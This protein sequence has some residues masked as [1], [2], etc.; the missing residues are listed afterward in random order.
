MEKGLE[1]PL[2][3]YR[4]IALL[5]QGGMAD[6]YLA[7]TQ[8]P[9]GF[10]K[11]LVV[12]LARFTGDAMHSTMFL[13][14]ARLAAQLSHPNVVQTYEIG[15]EGSRHY[16]VMEYLD[17]VNLSRLRQRSTRVGGI[18]LRLSVHIL[19]QVLEGLEYA[20]Q[21][22]G[23]DGKLLKVVHRDLTP[24]NIMVTAQGVVKILDFGIAKGVDT[25]SFTQA[26]R[27]SGKLNYMPPEQM[28]GESVDGR[29]D[30]FSVGVILAEAVLGHKFWG[31]QSGAMVAQQ[32]GQGQI[33][34][35]DIEGIDP[36]LRRICERALSA[37]RE[38]RYPNAAVFKA[39]LTRYLQSLGGPVDR[40]E[41]GQ[42]VSETVAEDRAKLQAVI[43]GQMQRISQ[44]TIAQKPPPPDLPHIEHTP[45]SRRSVHTETTVKQDD[46]KTNRLVGDDD[47][48]IEVDKPRHATPLPVAPAKSRMGLIAL[49][50]GA[51]L[52]GV[53]I[54]VVLLRP[55]GNQQVAS[56]AKTPPPAPVAA[57]TPPPPAPPPAPTT[58][59]LEVIVSPPDATLT[60]DGQSLGTNPYVGNQPR[61]T[62]VHELVVAA[63][64]FSPVT[65][66]FTL[67]RD[68][69]LQLHLD[70]VAPPV[71]K[72]EPPPPPPPQKVAAHPAPVKVKAAPHATPKTVAPPPDPT[73]PPPAVV[74]APP[75]APPADTKRSIDNDVFDK[76]PSKRALDS[77]VFDDGGK[78][79]TIDRDNPWKK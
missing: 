4:L 10:Q 6:V 62:Q 47:V 3:R 21:S 55:P 56:E 68:L 5:G 75:P 48:V 26:G 74:T 49:V 16:I 23:L 31:N 59:R 76:K 28:R 77:N 70:P 37:D 72:A 22:R 53:L 64:G 42:F 29:A 18:P 46:V 52:V 32:L 51:V 78:K 67:E 41:L 58:S 19:Q 39:D 45:S 54:T 2:G 13:D 17:G 1:T 69:M 34:S 25:H 24:S 14:E 38:T 44:L 7:C 79:A 63:K 73:P 40:E 27:Y 43:D 33:P 11:L 61:D 36:E 65:R 15:E 50:V 66:R 60:L 8:G 9:G 71:V 30:I 12:K 35:L 57:P 20:H